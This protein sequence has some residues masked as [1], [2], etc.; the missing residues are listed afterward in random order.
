MRQV[1]GHN[2]GSTAVKKSRTD[3]ANEGRSHVHRFETV[4]TG[5]CLPL[6]LSARSGAVKSRRMTLGV[7]RCLVAAGLI[8]CR[9]TAPSGSQS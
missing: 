6:L 1:Y 7:Y 4:E 9:R 5:R 3:L 8:L 2:L